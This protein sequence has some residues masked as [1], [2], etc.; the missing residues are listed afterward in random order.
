[1][2]FSIIRITPK[3]SLWTVDHGAGGTGVHYSRDRAFSAA[4]ADATRRA[5]GGE[6]VIVELSV[7]GRPLDRWRVDPDGRV[8]PQDLSDSAPR[9]GLH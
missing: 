3:G 9:A 8:S 5:Q 1:M 7:G 2:P 4:M 6:P